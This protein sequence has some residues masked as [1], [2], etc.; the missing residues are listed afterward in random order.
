VHRASNLKLPTALCIFVATSFA[1]RRA[2][3]FC[4][5]VTESVPPFYDPQSSGCFT[6]S[7]SAKLLYWT[8]ACIGY[9]LARAA[10]SQIDLETAT[11]VAAA[12]FEAWSGATCAGGGNPS[13]QAINEGPVDCPLVEYNKLGPNQHVIVFRDDEWPHND[14]NN[15]LGLTTVTFDIR[16]GEIYDADMEINS[17]IQGLVADGSVPSGGF[18]LNSI[19][20]HEAGHFLGL[21]HAPDPAAMMFARYHAGPPM[22]TEDDVDGICTIDP[23]DRTRNTTAGRIAAGPCDPKS[24]HGFSTECG[25]LHPNTGPPIETLDATGGG[26]CSVVGSKSHAAFAGALVF[27]MG[28]LVRRRSLHSLAVALFCLAFAKASDASVAIAV[29]FDDL[30]RA[31]T[32]VAVVTPVEQRSVWDGG[33]IYTYTHVRS[34]SIV[35]GEM[36]DDAWIQT[37]GGVVGDIGQSVEGEATF[38]VGSPSL[39]FLERRGG[40]AASTVFRVTA[41]GQG[42]FGIVTGDEMI[43]LAARG[44]IGLLMPN[45]PLD[46]RSRLLASDVLA[47]R[48]MEDAVRQI[49]SAWQRLHVR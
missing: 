29:S 39:L 18:D 21:A 42:Q 7:D 14:A 35:A 30:V 6:G 8:N 3:A 46:Q 22:L 41:R 26:G 9:S 37:M 27:V 38:V 44:D 33:R 47:N 40:T 5:T 4:R 45:R 31:A 19:M 23:P 34:T 36:S 48:P 13:I 11:S 1:A 15:T 28:F 12:A 20:T 25:S 17:T 43:R 24:R 32:A 49:V 16:T 10:S 2:D